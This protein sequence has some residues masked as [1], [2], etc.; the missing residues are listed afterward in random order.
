MAEIAHAPL[1]IVIDGA[2]ALTAE[3][4]RPVIEDAVIGIRGSRFEVVAARSDLEAVPEAARRIDGRDRVVTPGFVNVHTHAVLSMVRGVAEDMGFAPAYTPG[5]PHGHDVTT[6]EAVALA[7]LGALEALL[8]GSTFI[9][10]SYVH[11]LATLP[12]MGEIGLRTYSCGRIHDV[13]FT[14]VHERIWEYKDEIGDRTLGEA[15]ELAEKWHGGMDGRLGVHLA[16]HAPDTCSRPLLERVRATA[17]R[18]GLG[19]NTHLAQSQIEVERIAARDGMTPAQLLQDVG[20]LDQRLIA[21]HCLF[22]AEDDIPRVSAAG[23]HVAHIPKGN[24]T[25]GTA[26]PTS[27]LRRAGA[28]ITLATDN[29]HADM[30]EVMRWG[31]NIGRLQEGAVTD[32]WQPEDVFE[33]AT[34]S[35]ARAMGLGDEI[36]SLVAGKKADLV[37][38]DFGQ[39]HLTPAR[40]PLGNLVHVGQGRDVETVIVDGRIVVDGGRATLVDQDAIRREAAKAAADLWE[41]ARA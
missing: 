13:D 20:L 10:D 33:M 1:D 26:A 34:L 16:A 35:G 8:F 23:I 9:N 21:A 31:L 29:M 7:R 19:V 12:A 5:V 24:A 38:F 11:A 41:R 2:T 39:I 37:I 30:V 14:R 17:R 18:L 36:G 27:K 28:R 22:L 15:E 3:A 40:D 4:A 6:E 32:F 25:G